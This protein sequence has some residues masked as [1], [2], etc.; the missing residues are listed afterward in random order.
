MSYGRINRDKITR[1]PRQQY[2]VTNNDIGKGLVALAIPAIQYDLKTRKAV[3]YSGNALLDQ[4]FNG[5]YWHGAATNSPVDIGATAGLSSVLDQTRPWSIATKIFLDDITTSQEYVGD[6]N[7][8]GANRSIE[9]LVSAGV[10]Y[11]IGYGT[12]NSQATYTLPSTG[13]YDVMVVSSGGSGFTISLYVNGVLVNTGAAAT[14]TQS[15]GTTLRLMS[16]GAYTGGF[17]ALGH[18]YYCAFFHGDKSKYAKD[19]YKNPW[20]LLDGTTSNYGFFSQSAITGTLATTNANDTLAASGT[21]TIVGTL[22]RTNSNDTSAASGTTTIVGSLARTNANDTV[23]ASGTTT[24]TGSL[25]R[26]NANDT[27]VASGSVGSAVSGSLAYVNINDTLAATGTTTITGTLARTNANDS[28]VANGSPVIVGSL[29]TTNSN[30]T[31][32][33]SGAVGDA[34]I[35]TVSVT[36]ANDTLA[37][38]GT[39]TIIGS[40]AK[41]NIND[42]LSA[43][44]TTTIVGSASITNANDTLVASGSATGATTLTVQ[45]LLDIADAVWAHSTAVHIEL[46]LT[47]AWG[48]LGLDITAPLV[49]GQTEISFG[50]IVMAL[51]EASGNVT[52]ARQ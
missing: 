44:G 40:L 37:A 46:L 49:S 32:V 41:T 35:G 1:Q 5:N 52:C 3:T 17:G 15:A 28:V 26:T 48:R 20:Q 27:V 10:L 18:M 12:T 6:M 14:G 42:T 45:D 8:A 22:A 24:V 19:L 25:A 16:P 47:E 11:A 23:S 50:S 43:S 7:A 34:V 21:T 51:T 30:D 4:D 9:L 29:S 33:A 2:P 39:T 36:N 31:L 13:M 38:S